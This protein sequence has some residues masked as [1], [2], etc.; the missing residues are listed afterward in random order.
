VRASAPDAA[1][2]ERFR[3]DFEAVLGRPVAVGELIA[4]AVSGGPDSMAMLALAHAAFPDQAVAATVDHRLRPESADEAAMVADYCAAAGIPHETLAIA[5]PP[6]A[7]DNIQSWARQE[8]YTLLRRWAV[9]AGAAALATAHH[10]DDQAETFLMRAARGSGLSGLAAVRR[11]QNIEVTMSS[12][13]EDSPQ[14]MG[15]ALSLSPLTLVRPLLG[16]RHHELVAAAIAANVPFVDDPSNSDDR[17][18]RT[19]FRRLLAE[20]DWIDPVQI[21]RSAAWL[22]EADADLRAISQW[23]WKERGLPSGDFEARLDVAGLPRGVRRYLVRMAI[24]HLVMMLG[25]SGGWSSATNIESLLDSLEA[26]KAA[27]QAGIMASAKGDVW[28]FR[29]APPRRSH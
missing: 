20:A 6:D 14:G 18:D 10:A 2:I 22:A 21:G 13:V 25:M 5:T 17:F 16:W 28:H 7:G 3:S 23:L 29:E 27:T 8:R 4:L 19:R 11:R 12:S 15:L 26:G 9:D 24:D 1:S